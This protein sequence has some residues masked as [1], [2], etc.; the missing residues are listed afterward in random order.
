MVQGIRDMITFGSPKMNLAA[1]LSTFLR[2]SK[3]Y[4]GCHQEEDCSRP[5]EK[6]QMHGWRNFFIC[7]ILCSPWNTLLQILPLWTDTDIL[8][9]NQ[10]PRF[11]TLPTGWVVESP[12]VMDSIESFCNWWWEPTINNS[13]FVSLTNKLFGINQARRSETQASR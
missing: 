10:E 7:W 4:L 9:S 2:L 12:T 5:S 6:S 8:A 13:F 11:W 3:W 1:A